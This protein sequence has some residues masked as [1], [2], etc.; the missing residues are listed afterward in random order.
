MYCNKCGAPLSNSDKYCF[1]CGAYISNVQNQFE[2]NR[3][4]DN[5][6]S[7][8]L[9]IS[10]INK[11]KKIRT[12]NLLGVFSPIIINFIIL[13]AFLIIFVQ[14]P[15]DG[16][17]DNMNYISS[18]A[19]KDFLITYGLIYAFSFILNAITFIVMLTKLKE[20]S[21]IQE[22]FHRNGDINTLT[23]TL[24]KI[25]NT[26]ITVITVI[27]TVLFGFIFA[28]PQILFCIIISTTLNEI[29]RNIKLLCCGIQK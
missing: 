29:K 2:N 26:P 11:L 21:R 28:I 3:K 17:L 16:D 5:I 25:S 18:Y 27:D 9:N 19:L 10:I 7:C 6:N 1:K 12:V 14:G 22:N 24:N 13:A 20:F 15:L 23:T 8:N 4:N